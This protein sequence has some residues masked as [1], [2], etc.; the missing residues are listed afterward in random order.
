MVVSDDFYANLRI[1]LGW[2]KNPTLGPAREW[3]RW[4]TVEGYRE[5]DFDFLDA[6][7][8]TQLD[9]SV[10][11]F[12][13]IAE[14]VPITREPNDQEIADAKKELETILQI[15][16]PE[17]YY[18]LEAFRLEVKLND[19]LRGKLPEWV[20]GIKCRSELDDE[21]EPVLR[22]WIEVTEETADRGWILE[23]G[24]NLWKGVNAAARRLS[25]KHPISTQFRDSTEQI[26]A[27]G[28]AP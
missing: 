24:G 12:R 19:A 4:E 27:Q 17:R 21:D 11:A 22:I 15:T 18:A 10:T 1:A 26:Q 7:L 25:P 20:T 2:L 23:Q 3:L 5:K 6:T 9:T 14:S 16:Q 28:V 13:K 8:R